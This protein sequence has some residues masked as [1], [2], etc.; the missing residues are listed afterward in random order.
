MFFFVFKI[1]VVGV[2]FLI[3]LGEKIFKLFLFCLFEFERFLLFIVFEVELSML[4][5]NKYL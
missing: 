5:F 2:I 1:I 3:I 4:D